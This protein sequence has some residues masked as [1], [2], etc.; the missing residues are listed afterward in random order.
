MRKLILKVG[1]E[2]KCR[3]TLKNQRINN[4]QLCDPK[5]V[6]GSHCWDEIGISL[7]GLL[8]KFMIAKKNKNDILLT[9]KCQV[10][11]KTMFKWL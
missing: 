10:V 7:T 5:A 3:E 8:L 6:V 11:S 9:I 4:H 1:N 2:R